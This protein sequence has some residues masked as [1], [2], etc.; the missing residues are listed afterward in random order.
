MK[1]FALD[2]HMIDL[3]GNLVRKKL[4]EECPE[5]FAERADTIL[6]FIKLIYS[7]IRRKTI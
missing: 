7:A 3:K 4:E 1:D 6:I 5:L 2:I